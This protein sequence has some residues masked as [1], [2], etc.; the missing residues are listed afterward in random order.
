MRE[1]WWTIALCFGWLLTGVALLLF[2]VATIESCV[3]EGNGAFVFRTLTCELPPA[4]EF[5]PY[6]SQPWA[7]LWL[8]AFIA[9]SWVPAFWLYRRRAA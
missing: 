5:V 9:L 7:W 8:G 3:D 6:Y 1:P 4:S 2:A